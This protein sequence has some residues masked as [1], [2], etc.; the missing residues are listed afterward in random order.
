MKMTGFSIRTWQDQYYDGTLEE[1]AVKKTDAIARKAKKRGAY[2]EHK[3]D[4][5]TIKNKY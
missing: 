1:Q 2:G 4:L 5:H 3:K